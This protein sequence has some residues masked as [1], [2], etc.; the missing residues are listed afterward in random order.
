MSA[1]GIQRDIFGQL[2]AFYE[3]NNLAA[4]LAQNIHLFGSASIFFEDGARRD[5]DMQFK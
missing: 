3:G 1:L 4:T 2:D 5:P